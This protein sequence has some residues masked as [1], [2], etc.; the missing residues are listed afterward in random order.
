MKRCMHC[1]KPITNK[2]DYSY[3]MYAVSPS[4]MTFI[5]AADGFDEFLT[6]SGEY[7]R[8]NIVIAGTPGS[9]EGHFIH[10]KLELKDK[11][12]CG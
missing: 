11:F 4:T 6:R 8:G 1:K 3:K 10:Y 7:K 5:E 12:N 9:E 2:C